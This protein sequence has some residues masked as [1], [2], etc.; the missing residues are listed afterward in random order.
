MQHLI[1]AYI[2]A[3]EP[4]RISPF[5]GMRLIDLIVKTSIANAILNSGGSRATKKRLRKR[6]RTRLRYVVGRQN[7]V[8][9][10]S[11]AHSPSL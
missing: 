1:D 6:S 5:D 11:A 4:C 9:A 2:E 10:I 7:T 8:G 3:E